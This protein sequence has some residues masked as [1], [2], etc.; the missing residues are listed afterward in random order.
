MGVGYAIGN[1]VLAPRVY[2]N[3]PEVIATLVKRQEPAKIIL[4]N[5]LIIE[6]EVGLRYMVREIF[7]RRVYCPT[8]IPIG[9]NDIVVDIGANNGVFTL[10]AASITRNSVYAFEP[11]PRNL[12][13]LKR[14]IAVNGVQNIIAHGCAVS[15][16]VGLAKLFLHPQD[17]Q[18]NILSDHI[19]PDKIEQYKARSELHYLNEVMQ[20]ATHIEVLTTNLQ[21]IMDSNNLEQI[22]F[23]KLD[24][25]GAESTILQSTPDIYLKRIRKIS[26]EFHDQLSELNHSDIQNI[27]ERAG[28]TSKL[29]WDKK[30]PVG[31]MYAWRY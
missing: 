15:D 26:M 21:E 22:D 9:D 7:F 18:Q 31:Y 27:L 3:W 23:L 8:Y 28:F 5:G 4:K 19:I 2:E 16:K 11:S 30:S 29:K 1:V 6:S 20:S 14:N 13:I 25:E 12:E 17:G 10:F 24:C